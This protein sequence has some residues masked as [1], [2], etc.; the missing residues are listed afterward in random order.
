M[1]WLNWLLLAIATVIS[2]G[3]VERGRMPNWYILIII[4]LVWLGSYII[5]WTLKLMILMLPFI[6]I[7]GVILYLIGRGAPRRPAGPL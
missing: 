7:V 6:I 5:L 3:I 4:P 1:G 2:A